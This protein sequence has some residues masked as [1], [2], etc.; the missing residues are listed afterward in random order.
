MLFS[1]RL[2]VNLLLIVA[3]CV[4]IILGTLWWLKAYT[5]HGESVEVPDLTGMSIDKLEDALENTTLRYEVTDSIYSDEQPRGAVIIQNPHPGMQ[6]K[7]GRTIF[8]TVNSLLPE[9]VIMPDLTGKSRR[10]AIPMLEISGLQL[11][12]ARYVPDESCTDCVVDQEYK[13]KTIAAGDLIRKGEKITLMIGQQ[14]NEMIIMPR[15]MGM[16]YEQSLELIATYRLNVGAILQC[17]GCFTAADSAGA[18]VINQ[19]PSPGTRVPLGTFADL[20]LTTDTDLGN[21]FVIPVDTIDYEN[22]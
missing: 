8:I 17:D 10:V 1:R 6:V 9:M 22:P 16:S 7:E 15:F 21:T 2:L 5:Q 14:S 20:Y 12:A 13:G 4:L 11:E 3:T 19:L 18:I